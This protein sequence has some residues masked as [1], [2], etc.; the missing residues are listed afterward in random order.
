[1]ERRWLE[2]EL[3]AGRSIEAIA[4]EVGRD[5]STVAYWVNKHGL[6]SQLAA[7]HAA[8]GGIEEADL[9]ALVERALSVREIAAERGVS[10]TA[11]RHWLRRFDLRTQPAHYARRGAPKPNAIVR[12]CRRHGW[13]VFRRVGRSGDYRCARC[14]VARVGRHRRRVKD[15]LVAEAGGACRLCG[16]D[17]YSGALQF[18]HLD[19]SESGS[20][21]R[22]AASRGR[23]RS[24]ARRRE[25][26]CYCAPTVTR[27]WRRDSRSSRCLP[28]TRVPQS[29]SGP[30]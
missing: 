20:D 4:R 2:R 24:C 11:V 1:M 19:P 16:Y 3:A 5:P 21:S 27:R 25:S 8:R 23:S 30:G 7:R 29:N 18:P 28:I 14:G 22:V 12:E 15:I 17:R 13:T 26:A 9:R 10:P 6:T